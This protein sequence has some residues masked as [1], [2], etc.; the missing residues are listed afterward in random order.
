M[1]ISSSIKSL[2]LSTVNT[3]LYTQHTTEE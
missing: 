1:T 3:L 2:M